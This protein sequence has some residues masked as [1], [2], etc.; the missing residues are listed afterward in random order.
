MGGVLPMAYFYI[1]SIIKDTFA[2]VEE[3]KSI[4][5][6]PVL[7][8]VCRNKSD[9]KV[10]VAK[11]DNS[12]IVELFKLIRVNLQ[13]VLRKKEQKVVLLT[14]TVSLI[15]KSGSQFCGEQQAECSLNNISIK[16]HRWKLQL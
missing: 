12:S 3:L 15:Q 2:S 14:S 9:S 16:V 10:V 7:G 1:M 8:E 5:N 6:I 11:G 4:T 13:F